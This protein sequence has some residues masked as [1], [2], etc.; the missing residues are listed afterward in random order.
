MGGMGI[1]QRNAQQMLWEENI[2]STIAIFAQMAI[3]AA[4]FGSLI[5]IDRQNPKLMQTGLL[6]GD[7]SILDTRFW[8]HHQVPKR[9][10]VM[11]DL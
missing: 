7:N 8:I 11:L 1:T 6:S 9:Y 4:S 5:Q 2:N 3:F 10:F